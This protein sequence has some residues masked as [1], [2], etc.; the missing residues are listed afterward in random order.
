MLRSGCRDAGNLAG[1]RRASVDG[2]GG[3]RVRSR[4]VG[5]ILFDLHDIP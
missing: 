2:G 1:R 3:Q 4:T 5:I